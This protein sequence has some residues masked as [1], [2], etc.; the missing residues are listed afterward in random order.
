VI[1]RAQFWVTEGENWVQTQAEPAYVGGMSCD[2][3]ATCPASH[4][5]FITKGDANRGYDQIDGIGTTSDVVRPA[6]INGKG[7]VRVP[8]LGHVRLGFD[9]LVA[10][11][12]P[13]PISGGL[14][15][16]PGPLAPIALTA[17]GSAGV[18]MGVGLRRGRH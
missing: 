15:P 6:W 9:Q 5:G 18:V 16:T 14:P 1:H 13:A 11:T 3:I 8:W 4:A 17:L 2:Q 10:G 7:M 12:G